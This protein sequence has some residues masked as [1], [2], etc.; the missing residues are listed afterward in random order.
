MSK[1]IIYSIAG[2]IGFSVVAAGVY[3]GAPYILPKK[4]FP[5]PVK[6]DLTG[7]VVAPV[8]FPLKGYELQVPNTE[9][10]LVSLN[11]VAPS[12]K[13]DFPMARFANSSTGKE[14]TLTAYDDLVSDEIAGWRAVPIA[15]AERGTST[16]WYVARLQK[17]GETWSHVDSVYLGEDLKMNTVKVSGENAE[18]NYFVHNRTQASTDVPSV[19]TTAI[20]E[21]ASGTVLQAGR[22]PKAEAVIEYKSFTGQYLWQKTETSGGE[23]VTPVVADKF[24]LRFDGNRVQLGTDCNSGSA[25]FATEPLP[26]NTFKVDAIASTMMFC[27]SAQE[28][29]YFSMIQ[30]IV[31]YQ[32][33]TDSLSFTLTDGRVM[34]FIPKQRAPQFEN[35]QTSSDVAV[36]II[37]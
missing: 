1:K 4:N 31:S 19:N 26:A 22:N 32:E 2:L 24:T 16:K 33:N 18:I 34:I 7:I 14:S 29:E 6:K 20:I 12:A 17:N 27:E 25:T 13:R 36:P 3:F 15:L 5:P 21:L 35:T 37:E 9:G 28:S 8:Q 11:L 23:V 30:K 10:Q